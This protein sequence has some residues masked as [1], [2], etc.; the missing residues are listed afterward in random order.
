[1][2][3][4]E[5]SGDLDEL[6]RSRSSYCVPNRTSVRLGTVEWNLGPIFT[7][8]ET[9]DDDDIYN[10]LIT[11]AA[12]VC[13]A[14]QVRGSEP[15]SRGI[16]KIR[17]QCILFPAHSFT[18]RMGVGIDLHRIPNDPEDP[19]STT[20]HKGSTRSGFE[21]VNIRDLTERGCTC[22]P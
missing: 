10:D 3:I 9:Y 22:T 5:L 15:G 16:V 21:W 14:I 4:Q 2:E 17:M 20:P 11:R 12:G 19:S 8:R 7:E 6:Y 1:M 18:P 13:V